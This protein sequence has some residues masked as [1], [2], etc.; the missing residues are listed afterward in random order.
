[1]RLLIAYALLPFCAGNHQPDCDAE[2]DH[3]SALQT[4]TS[5]AQT[6]KKLQMFQRATSEGGS[7]TLEAVLASK[8]TQMHQEESRRD[9]GMF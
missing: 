6:A 5:E 4:R 7:S 9:G 2:A 8:K 3:V 1:M